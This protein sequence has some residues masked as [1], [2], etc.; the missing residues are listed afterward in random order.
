MKGE[1]TI[2]LFDANT[3]KLT[4]EVTKHNLVTGAANDFLQILAYASTFNIDNLS[5]SKLLNRTKDDTKDTIREL[6]GGVLVFSEA[7]DESHKYPIG[8]EILSNIGHAGQTASFYDSE[9]T[10]AGQFNAAESE[11]NVENKRYKFVWDFPTSACNGDIASICLTNKMVG[12]RG[13]LHDTNKLISNSGDDSKSI[14][15][16]ITDTGYDKYYGYEGHLRNSEFNPKRGIGLDGNKVYYTD[17]YYRS[18]IPDFSTT[19]SGYNSF[20]YNYGE[21]R[22]LALKYNSSSNILDLRLIKKDGTYDDYTYN[23]TNFIS[24]LSTESLYLY[25]DGYLTQH[26]ANTFSLSDMCFYII[27]KYTNDKCWIA[28]F[29]ITNGTFKFLKLEETFKNYPILFRYM[30]IPFCVVNFNIHGCIVSSITKII[31]DDLSLGDKCI[32]LPRDIYLLGS[33]YSALCYGNDSYNYVCTF[34]HSDDYSYNFF[35][36]SACPNACYLA[37]INNQSDVL[38]KTPDKTMKIIYTLS[39]E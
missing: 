10:Y 39:E 2:Q 5:V 26:I 11:F 34:S 3:G 23:F 24:M 32:V 36:Y 16:I 22:F 37:T 38:T 30:D 18:I 9:D 19:T 12:D 33:N 35:G 29:N 8:N 28:R 27:Y 17:K 15:N 6:Y 14:Y 31:N 20:L 1:T 7:I 25:E 4:D 21:Y 13:L